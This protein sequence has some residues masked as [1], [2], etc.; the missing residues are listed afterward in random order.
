MALKQGMHPIKV[1]FFEKTGGELLDIAFA[2]NGYKKRPISDTELFFEQESSTS[3][4]SAQVQVHLFPNPVDEYVSIAFANLAGPVK[5]SIY[6]QSGI[7]QLT[8]DKVRTGQKLDL[9]NLSS[10]LYFAKLVDAQGIQKYIKLI[11]Y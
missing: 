7:E 6:D 11:K 10:G 8:F 4:V 5:I 2:L 1:T 3:M 9:G